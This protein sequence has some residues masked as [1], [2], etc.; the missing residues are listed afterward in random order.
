METYLISVDLNVW[1]IVTTKYKVLD[2][3]PTD[4]D[5]K[6]KNELNA[7]A[8]HALLCGLTKDMFVKL[9]H[10]KSAHEIWD[11]LEIIYQG[12]KKVKE[13]NIIT[14][15]NQFE[16]LRIK[17][18]ETIASY[19][20]RIDKIVNSRRGLG[21]IVDEQDVDRKVIRT[22]LPKFE[23]KVS[24]LE[25]KKIF[26]TMTLDNLQGIL[27]AYEM[28]IGSNFSTSKETTFRV[29]KKEELDSES[30]LSDAIEAL[31][32]RNLKNKYKGKL[33]FK[34]F[35]HGK[36]GHFVAQ[37]PLSDL[38][39]EE[40]KPENFYKKKMWN[41]KK[42]FNTFKKEKSLFTKEDSEGE[43]DYSR[44]EGDETLFM[45]KIEF[46]STSKFEKSICSRPR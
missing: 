14:L 22:L 35:N 19:F 16:A 42:K 11:K 40:K 25:E 41:P 28:R 21:E 43:L 37:C 32:V 33:P 3:I 36:I 23:T 18:D 24:T 46:S 4:P 15:K 12:D 10:C 5:D 38:N 27:T 8:K 31:L 9:M 7:R 2:I 26:S 44:C 29:E 1:N 17:D 30:K 13:S 34:C 20:L 45:A 39:S 6:K